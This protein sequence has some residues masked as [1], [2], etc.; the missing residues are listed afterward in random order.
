MQQIRDNK[1]EMQRFPLKYLTEDT[2]EEFNLNSIATKIYELIHFYKVNKKSLSQVF[3]EK[4]A[5]DHRLG[6][7]L[8]CMDKTDVILPILNQVQPDGTLYLKEYLMNSGHAHGLSVACQM[9]DD[10]FQKVFIDN[11]SLKE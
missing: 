1:L 10:I 11:C 5:Q 3:L 8:E 7:L 4:K 2:T 6:Y 9:N